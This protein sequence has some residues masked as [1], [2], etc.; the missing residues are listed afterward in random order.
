M[1]RGLNHLRYI[2]RVLLCFLA[3]F[4]RL[5]PGSVAS[6]AKEPPPRRDYAGDE[7]CRSCHQSKAQTYSQTSHHLASSWPSPR[8]IKGSFTPGSNI[9]K[10]AN[11]YLHFGMNVNRNGYFQSAVE[12]LAPSKTLARTERID[13]VAGS[14]RKGQSYLFW[15]GDELFQLPVT[16][17]TETNSWVN[18]PSYPD[19]S[20]HF[21]KDII[22]RCLECHAS[23]FEWIPG[24]INRYRKTSLV[25]GITCERCHGPGREH[26]ARH[27]RNSS[28]PAGTSES[29]VN[30]AS[31]TRDRQIDLCGLCHSGAGTPIVPSLTFLPGDVLD[32]Y[33][34]IPYASPED[35]VDV[36]GSQ[37]QLLKRSRCYQSTTRLTCTTCHDVHTT[38]RDAAAFSSHCL[39]CHEPKQCGQYPK[40]GDTI[41]R[42]CID[43]HMPVQQ[44]HVLFSNT[45]GKRLT[46]KVRNHQIG[47]YRDAELH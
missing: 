4:L 47:I 16:F 15:K 10:T 40:I 11:P 9:L 21:D 34:D 14:A 23:Y 32:D 42:N 46:P 20:P 36:H 39:S 41:V 12:E 44:S 19:G 3:L 24:S 2:P 33:I 29:I 43:C 7:V 37:V 18:S 17:W 5:T 30:P 1:V 38:Q 25:L 35:V 45:N 28:L 22:P 13:V 27:R 6:Q 26:A 31:L 8:T